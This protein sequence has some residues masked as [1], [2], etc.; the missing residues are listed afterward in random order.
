MRTYIVDRPKE[1]L[2]LL[3]GVDRRPILKCSNYRGIRRSSIPSD[4]LAD[5]VN[6]HHESDRLANNNIAHHEPNHF[7]YF[8]P[9]HVAIAQPYSSPIVCRWS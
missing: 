9:N 5:H 4:N 6:T 1:L 8:K 2:Q 3:Q 7:A